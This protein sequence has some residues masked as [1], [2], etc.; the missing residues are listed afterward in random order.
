METI[1]ELRT[2]SHLTQSQLA[3]RANATRHAV[4]RMEQHLYPTPLPSIVIALSEITGIYE[5]RIAEQYLREVSENRK[6]H[7]ELW[8]LKYADSELLYEDYGNR[9]PFAGFRTSLAHIAGIRDSAIQFCMAFSIHPYTLS[10]Y[11]GFKADFPHQIDIA[12]TEAGLP[13]NITTVLKGS[14]RFNRING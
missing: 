12:L 10:E 6:I 3:S 13:A 11:E 7:G 2:H 14:E 4:L 9:H 1:R 8:G 5:T